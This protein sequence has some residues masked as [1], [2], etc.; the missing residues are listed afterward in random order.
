M[1]RPLCQQI[2]A[3]PGL[4][5]H[6]APA[7]TA[8]VANQPSRPGSCLECPKLANSGV[9]RPRVSPIQ[10]SHLAGLMCLYLGATQRCV[11]T[12]G[13]EAC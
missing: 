1:S 4:P 12:H 6:S 11:N 9:W 3:R 7:A 2:I 10:R 8:E 13:E 5:K